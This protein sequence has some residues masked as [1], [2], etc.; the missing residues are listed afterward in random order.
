MRILAGS[1]VV[2]LSAGLA[3]CGGN[4]AEDSGGKVAVATASA[5]GSAVSTA[6]LPVFVVLIPGSK[7]VSRVNMN[8]AGRT[9]GAVVVETD[10]SSADVLAFYRD[11]MAKN[12]LKVAM[13]TAT[14]DGAMLVGA[15]EG[16]GRMLNVVV[17]KGD[18]GKTMV[19]LTHAE[20]QGG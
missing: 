9:G 16:E 3:A 2:L 12:G 17:G 7:A 1:V 19:T 8:D 5:G 20:K 4:K 13:E 14:G 10:K 18:D 6:D 15:S 11:V